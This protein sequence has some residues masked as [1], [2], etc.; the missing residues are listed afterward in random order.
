[1]T[2]N[3]ARLW[4]RKTKLRYL[5]KFLHY[6]Q[7]NTNSAMPL[8]NLLPYICVVSLSNKLALITT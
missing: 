5:S 1:M 3:N 4:K 7:Y 6:L 8:N 2:E